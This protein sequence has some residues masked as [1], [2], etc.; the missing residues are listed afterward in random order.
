ME[1]RKIKKCKF[2]KRKTNHIKRGFGSVGGLTGNARWEC[3]E[4]KK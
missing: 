3:L 4:C 1:D 2:C